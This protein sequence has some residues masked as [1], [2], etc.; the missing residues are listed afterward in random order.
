MD[1]HIKMNAPLVTVLIP[2][3]NAAGTIERALESALSQSYEPK[4]VV[5][6]NDASPDET[7]VIVERYA[8]RNVRLINLERNIGE[9]GAMNAGIQAAAGEYVAFLDADDEWHESKLE[10]QLAILRQDPDLIFVTSDGDFVK[11]DG[12]KVSTV[13]DGATPVAGPE[14]WKMLLENNFVAKPCVVAQRA[15]LLE[16]NGFD[17][18]LRL[19]GDQDMWIRLAAM[20][21]IAVVLESLVNIYLARTSL[22]QS[23]LRN[24]LTY[25]LPMIE[26]HVNNLSHRLTSA[27]KRQILVHRWYEVGR[28][29]CEDGAWWEGTR[30]LWRSVCAAYRVR[31]CLHVIMTNSPPARRL[32]KLIGRE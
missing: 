12:E 25:L 23:N 11:H 30:F 19:A 5:V 18:T 16:C 9:C 14:A 32:K 2:A 1:K 15:A 3:Y 7:P 31:I 29:L 20:G 6:V 24:E 26:G 27:E 4:E 8:D 28:S 17:Q 13:Y 22:T 21:P 10:K